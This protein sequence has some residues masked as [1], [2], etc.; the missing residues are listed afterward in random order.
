MLITLPGIERDSKENLG[1]AGTLHVKSKPGHPKTRWLR[2]KVAAR[3]LELRHRYG[4]D[5]EVLQA[6]VFKIF[7]IR[8]SLYQINNLLARKAPS[9][10]RGCRRTTA[11]NLQITFQ[12]ANSWRSPN[13]YL[14]DYAKTIFAVGFFYA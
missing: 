12:A 14:W 9:R 6:H 8:A 7:G 13:E 11:S 3:V 4:W 5:A 1:G 2:G 10:S